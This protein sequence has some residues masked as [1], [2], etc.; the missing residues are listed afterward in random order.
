MKFNLPS[1]ETLFIAAFVCS[2][3]VILPATGQG[4][5]GTNLLIPL[6]ASVYLLL[7]PSSLLSSKPLTIFLLFLGWGIL[8][9]PGANHL[10]IAWQTQRKIGVIY[11]YAVVVWLYG[12][13][14][15]RHTQNLVS[16]HYFA[17][18]L[19]LLFTFWDT[20]NITSFNSDVSA[21]MAFNAN[22]YGY[23]GFGGATIALIYFSFS[24]RK[25]KDLLLLVATLV[26]V[27]LVI[28]ASSS[29]AGFIITSVLIGLGLIALFMRTGLTLK[30]TLVLGLLIFPALT[31]GITYYYDNVVA[32]SHLL[33]RL[34]RT[35]GSQPEFRFM[36]LVEAVS[37]GLN[38]VISGVG[39]GNYALVPRSFEP[40]SFS[41]NTY[42]EAFAN[43]GFPGFVLISAFIG[44]YVLAIRNI[45]CTHKGVNREILAIHRSY[46]LLYAVYGFFYVQF[47]SVEFISFFLTMR[48][49]LYHLSPKEKV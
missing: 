13:R 43:Y 5:V 18:F 48:L 20:N 28:T 31:I 44:E 19:F 10:E 33:E 39:G 9:L 2:I 14:S 7:F 40:G 17:L 22:T 45:A 12:R 47:L 24:Q 30:R 41:H 8:V 42:A 38:N 16:I 25:I 6:Y 15:T 37:I 26:S 23:V 4:A 21:N 34:N 35:N 32:E 1:T 27:I 29:R 11:L 49:Q 3:L 46:I 36:H